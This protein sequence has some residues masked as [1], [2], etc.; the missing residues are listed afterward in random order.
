MK[1]KASFLTHSTSDE[2]FIV[3]TSDASFSG[4]VKGNKTL[5][6]IVE[7][8][9]ED[10]TKEAVIKAMREKFDA[11]EGVIEKDVERVIA[12][13]TKIGALEE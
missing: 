8:L 9:K 6:A 5:G 13:L 11:P 12:E 2:S 3:P 10:T 7:L 4:M 1:L